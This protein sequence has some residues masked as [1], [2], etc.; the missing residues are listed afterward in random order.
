MLLHDV[1]LSIN[2]VDMAHFQNP[3]YGVWRSSSVESSHQVLMK[4]TSTTSVTVCFKREPRSKRSFLKLG[5]VSINTLTVH[6]TRPRC[7]IWQIIM[8]SHCPISSRQS[9]MDG[10]KGPPLGICIHSSLYNPLPKEFT[11]IVYCKCKHCTTARCSCRAKNL[12]CSGA[13]AC[14][15]GICH[16]PYSVVTESD[17]D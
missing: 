6:T 16:N 5:R 4:Q 9:G 3:Q 7:G 13:C 15:D 2:S 11:D 10:M 1:I 17:S 8:V 14:H 12:K